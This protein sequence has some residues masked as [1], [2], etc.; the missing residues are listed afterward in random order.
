MISLFV[1]LINNKNK[2]VYL[3]IIFLFLTT[4]CSSR[5]DKMFLNLDKYISIQMAQNKDLFEARD[6]IVKNKQYRYYGAGWWANR[7][8]EYI[9]PTINNFSDALI[10]SQFNSTI[11]NK[12]LVRDVQYWNWV[13]DSDMEKLRQ[14]SEK[15]IIFQNAGYVMSLY[16]D[17]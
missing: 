14:Q 11:K 6:F 8:L 12:V 2:Y 13:G 10:P 17:E 1:F 16:V 15:H 3:A 4:P 7:R 9:L 5:I